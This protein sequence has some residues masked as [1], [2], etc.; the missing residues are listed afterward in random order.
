MIDKT[1][2]TV[3]I[4][5]PAYN[6]CESISPLIQTIQSELND[7]RLEIIV[8]DDASPD[9]TGK[10]IEDTHLKNVTVLFNAPRI[11]LAKSIRRGI[12]KTTGDYIVIMDSDGN[13]QPQYLKSMIQK[14]NQ[15]DCISASRFLNNEVQHKTSQSHAVSNPWRFR[16]TKI[17]NKI[18]RSLLKGTITD[19]FYGFL[20]INKKCLELCDYTHIFYGYGDYCMRLL[21]ALQKQ[22]VNISE[23]P[24]INGP[25][26]AGVGNKNFAPIFAQY[27]NEVLK[28][29]FNNS[30]RSHV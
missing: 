14:L 16:T 9:F 18:T 30:K 27:S 7:T 15:Y 6:E 11:G 12:E 28:T 24:V 4:V 5:L 20:I 13:H 26:L 22:N 17:F 19:Y 2:K 23:I 10:K 8:V 29:F 3:S 21:N 25:R 1:S